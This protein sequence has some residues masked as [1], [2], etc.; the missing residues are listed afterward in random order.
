MLALVSVPSRRLASLGPGGAGLAVLTAPASSIGHHRPM[1][2]QVHGTGACVDVRR[3]PYILVMIG[4]E[5]RVFHASVTSAPC[6]LDAPSTMTLH[7]S[8][9]GD[10]A[11]FAADEVALDEASARVSKQPSSILWKS[12][13]ASQR[14][15]GAK[16]SASQGPDESSGITWGSA[17]GTREADHAPSFRPTDELLIPRRAMALSKRALLE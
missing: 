17:R 6:H 3:A 9:F 10:V 5:S 13:R 16:F 14:S 7:V 12:K 11:G 4:Q 2:R 8:T 1:S 15:R